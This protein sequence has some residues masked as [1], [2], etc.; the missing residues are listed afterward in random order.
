MTDR[1]LALWPRPANALATPVGEAA[2][3]PEPT[4]SVNVSE[5]ADEGDE[6]SVSSHEGKYRVLWRWLRSQETD[7]VRL[8]FADV[9]QI[10]DMP[11]PPAARDHKTHWY[12]Y[13]GTALGRAIRDAGWKASQVNLADERVT[14]VR[15][16]GD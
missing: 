1:L 3:E 12:G 10:L 6:E 4:A 11:L 16:D 13:R 7:E 9:E 15:A 8:S 14:F 5:I 2:Y